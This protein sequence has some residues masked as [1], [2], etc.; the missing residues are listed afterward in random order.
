[1]TMQHAEI[2]EGIEVDDAQRGLD[3]SPL[4]ATTLPPWIRA[5]YAVQENF[6]AL[7]ERESWDES[8]AALSWAG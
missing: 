8:C 5:V 2:M 3:A 1:M 4:A 7:N 6:E